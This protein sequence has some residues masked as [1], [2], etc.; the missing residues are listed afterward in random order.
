[1]QTKLRGKAVY[2]QDRCTAGHTYDRVYSGTRRCS[3]CDA[4]RGRNWRR[5]NPGG[6]AR[7]M[8]EWR[9]RQRQANGS[10]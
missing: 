4:E 7:Q 3:L 8:R 1:M 5:L 2:R 10:R 9:A 6:C